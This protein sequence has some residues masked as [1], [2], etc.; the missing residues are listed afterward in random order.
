MAVARV[1][2]QQKHLESNNKYLYNKIDWHLRECLGSLLIKKFG[3]S[4]A[5]AQTHTT[6]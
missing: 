6:N 4:E 3:S 2:L 1:L 5:F